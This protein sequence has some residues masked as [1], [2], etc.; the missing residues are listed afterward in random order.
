MAELERIQIAKY[1]HAIHTMQEV[2]MNQ[3]NDIETLKTLID[4]QNEVIEYLHDKMIQLERDSFR[5]WTKEDCNSLY[6]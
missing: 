3:R 6:Y 4:K 1:D 5:V 2:Q